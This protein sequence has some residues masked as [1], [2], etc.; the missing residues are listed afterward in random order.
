MNKPNDVLKALS[1]TLLLEAVRE[2]CGFEEVREEVEKNYNNNRWWPTTVLDWRL[3]MLVA[4]WST[5]VSYAHIVH[6]E[7]VVQK[8]N[9][10]G[11]EGLQRLTESELRDLVRPL[12]LPASRLQYFY[13]L[14]AFIERIPSFSEFS[15]TPHA[16]IIDRLAREVD[17]SGYKVAQ[18]AVLYAKGYHCGIIPVDS[19]MV[20]ML[21]PLIPVR[22]P[23]AAIAHDILRKWLEDIVAARSRDLHSIAATCG[24][25]LGIAKEIAPT[26]W[27][28]LV[29]IYYKRIH[30]NKRHLIGPFRRLKQPAEN[31]ED[32]TPGLEVSKG[33]GLARLPSIVLEG[34]DGSG[35]TSLAR[36]FEDM[37]YTRIHS[38]LTP[39]GEDLFQKYESLICGIGRGPMILD[40][41][42]ISE[43]VY[44]RTIRSGSRLST[45]Q[46]AYLLNLLADRAFVVFHLE[47]EPEVLAARR[48]DTDI[49]VLRT[50]IQGYR[51][52]FASEL[53]KI[54]PVYYL[55]P[56]Q[57]AP[58]YLV[59]M[60]RSR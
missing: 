21:Q 60:F 20:E 30:W 50:L 1:E 39:Q 18:C 53:G 33:T 51:E 31:E 56:S 8:T 6:Y 41:C 11:W 4:G 58:G 12:G 24:Y 59:R 46:C 28:H 19:G 32:N 9:N 54:M 29:L 3:R 25:N 22:L 48:P 35:K 26:W 34:V 42:F 2:C 27:V 23:Q 17:G 47:E 36:S 37:G 7:A 49:G 16:E 55:R 15:E 40:R 52:F 44:G 14:R 57:I 45:E 5:R 10:L 13:S 38:P 43:L